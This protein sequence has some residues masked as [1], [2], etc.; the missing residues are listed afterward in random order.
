MGP[1][2]CSLLSMLGVTAPHLLL[3]AVFQ[4]FLLFFAL[5]LLLFFALF[6]RL[7]FALSLLA[8]LLL[9]LGWC[10]RLLRGA[11]DADALLLPRP[12]LECSIP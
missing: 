9:F 1:Y 5:F 6:L 3:L 10:L 7:S 12:G 4:G 11:D 2:L 8:L